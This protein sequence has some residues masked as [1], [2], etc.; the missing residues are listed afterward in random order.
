VGTLYI[1]VGGWL[2]GPL[3]QVSA[4]YLAA[5]AKRGGGA[6]WVAGRLQDA[7]GIARVDDDDTA[8]RHQ[9]ADRRGAGQKAQASSEGIQ[10]VHDK[11]KGGMAQQLA[12]LMPDAS[13]DE[14]ALLLIFMEAF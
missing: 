1:A 12:A 3:S 11:Q 5:D 14:L 9:Q 6:L 13:D 8:G 4:G 7:T 10:A 2:G